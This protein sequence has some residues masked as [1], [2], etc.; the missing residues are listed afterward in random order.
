MSFSPNGHGDAAQATQAAGS[1]A[2]P[3]HALLARLEEALAQA[4]GWLPFDRFMALALYEP[5]LGY[6]A[7]GRGIFG[8]LP[9]RQAAGGAAGPGSDFVTAPLVSG[10]FAALLARQLAQAL[11]ATGVRQLWEFGAGTGDLA[12]QIL[13]HLA[14]MEKASGEVLLES[15]HIVELSAPLRQR[16]QERLARWGE[17][18]RW[19]ERLPDRLQ[20]V[21]LGNEVLDAL[22]VQLLARVGGRWHE[23]G[24]VR[25]CDGELSFEDRPTELRPP[26][27]VAG[28]HD[29]VTEIHPQAEALVRTLGER[30]EQGAA[31]FIDY[32]FPEG[33]YYHPQRHMGTLACHHAHRMDDRPLER[34]GEKDITAHVNFTGVALAAQE[35]GLQV[36]GYTTQGR[37]LINC[38]WAEVLDALPLDAAG[39]A[40]RAM[41][42]KLVLEHEMGEL[43]KVLL[44]APE[45]SAAGWQPLGFA[46]GDRTHTL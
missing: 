1:V 3:S 7:S 40:E 27:E 15:Y 8:R 20:A 23:R 30:L 24:V 29:Y 43:F 41:A 44:L 38:G 14:Q 35:V 5:G 18:V 32:G 26:L 42:A 45:A 22:P 39:L 28:A 21:V 13:Q 37:F 11:R 36:L 25:R 10:V 2:P 34:V 17:R 19:H 31:L 9:G 46:H 12:L 6:Y 16:Q 33:E 4:G